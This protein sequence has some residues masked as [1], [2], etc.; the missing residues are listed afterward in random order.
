MQSSD[1]LARLGLYVDDAVSSK[2]HFLRR[3]ITM[4]MYCRLNGSLATHLYCLRYY[5]LA[6]SVS[7]GSHRNTFEVPLKLNLRHLSQLR[8][9]QPPPPGGERLIV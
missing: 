4:H 2:T 6:I 1:L 8:H 3:R 9:S 5:S 7:P